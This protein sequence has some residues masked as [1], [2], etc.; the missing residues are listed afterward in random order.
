[1]ASLSPTEPVAPQLAADRWTAYSLTVWAI[2]MLG[3]AF[4]IYESTIMQLVTPLLIKE[5]GIVPATMGYITTLSSWV[6]LIGVFVFPAL[7]DLYGRRPILILTILSYSLFTGFTGF[8][9]GPLQLLIFT[10][11]TR[12]ALRGETPVGAIMVSETA[13]TRWRATA[14][15]GLVGGYPFGYM[16]C[17]LTALVVVPL[18][19]WRALYWLGI[20]PALLVLW[21]RLGVKESPRFERV[22][23]EMVKEGLKKRLDI[24]LPVREYPREMLIAAL[25]YFFY[26]FT[27]F[28]WSAWMPQYLANEKHLGF[29]T[30]ASY[31][32]IWMGCAIFAYYLCGWLCDLFGRRYVIPSFVLPAAILLVVMGHLDTPASLFWVGL[33]LNFLITGSFGAGLGYNTELFPTQIRGTAVG[34]AFTFGSA[35][36]GLA[37]AIVGWIA[38]THSIAAALPLLALSFFLIVPMFLFVAREMTRKELIDFVGQKTGG[39]LHRI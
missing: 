14:L 19:G 4:D 10:S 7:A 24:L 37:P 22:T 31:L 16:L 1:M 32:S 33:V 26:L 38:T 11:V 9:Q 23:T 30:T 15:G 21:V 3:F 36:G 18:W 12:I 13:P 28:G 35:G 27:W 5:W 34:A 25:L 8:A 6:G 20:L 17:S 2:C 39:A 29:Q